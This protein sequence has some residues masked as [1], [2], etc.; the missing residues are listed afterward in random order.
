MTVS[1]GLV[2]AYGLI[3]LILVTDFILSFFNRSVIVNS[4]FFLGPSHDMTA[5]QIRAIALAILLVPQLTGLVAILRLKKWGRSL[6]TISNITLVLFFLY[7]MIFEYK[8]VNPR[9]LIAMTVFSLL[10]L[11]YSQS[12]SK[13]EMIGLEAGAKKKILVVDDDRGFLK[14]M[15]VNLSSHGFEVLTADT[16]EQGLD[17]ARRYRPNLIILDVILP[18]IKGREVCARL[19]KEPQTQ[20]IPVVFLTAKNS[21]DDVK[22]ELEL[23]AVSHF[24][25]PLNFSKVLAEIKHIL[26]G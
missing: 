17:L 9:S 7:R 10:A 23:G 15:K 8:Q 16:G 20:N 26:K 24:T 22:A 21:P 2:M 6:V 12:K 14:L 19:K 1:R 5:F 13:E 11:F 25:K 4:S 18:K 3:L